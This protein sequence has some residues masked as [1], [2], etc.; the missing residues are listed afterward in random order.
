MSS[1]WSDS[2]LFVR[3]FFLFLFLSFISSLIYGAIAVVG[4]HLPRFFLRI[5]T[6]MKFSCKCCNSTTF[7]IN[8]NGKLFIKHN[9]MVLQTTYWIIFLLTFFF[10]Y[11]FCLLCMCA[12]ASKR[13]RI[14]IDIIQEHFVVSHKRFY[15][16]FICFLSTF[17]SKF[18]TISNSFCLWKCLSNWRRKTFFFFFIFTSKQH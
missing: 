15:F 17:S 11:R 7:T 14:F 8:S 6:Q 3:F 1:T 9:W 10:L 16:A 4:L 2:F 12:C 5:S 18:F 13:K